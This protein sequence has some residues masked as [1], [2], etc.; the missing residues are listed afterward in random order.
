MKFFNR[1]ISWLGFNLRVLQEAQKDSV[2]LFERI[3]FLSIYS[4]NLD[5]FFR[6]RYSVYNSLKKI[7]K[8]TDGQVDMSKSEEIEHLINEQLP[9]F[10]DILRNEILPELRKQNIHLYYDET[11]SN[12]TLED[13]KSLFL[14]KILAYIQPKFLSIGESTD[15]IQNNALYLFVVLEDDDNDHSYALVNIPDQNLERF[16]TV[17]NKNGE[18][19][20][21]FLDDI[22][23]NNLDSIF[24]D[25]KVVSS[26]SIKLTRNADIDIEDEWSDLFEEQVVA[27]IKKR[28]M[29]SPARLLY[30]R[31]MPDDIKVF[32]AK[33]FDLGKRN[34]IEGGKYHNLKDL[35]SL[36]N[37]VGGVLRYKSNPPIPSKNI[38]NNTTIF[39]A[40]ASKD[41]IV[42]V[43][44]QS[45]DT[46]LRFFNE[47][48]IDPYVQELKV[49]LYRVA[50]DSLITNALISAARNGKKVTAFVELKARFDE[51]NNLAWAKQMKAAGVRII[52]SIPGMKVHAKVALVKRKNGL[53]AKYYS[54]LSTGNFNEKTARFYTDH[55]L[56][57]SNKNIT[58]EIDI[59]FAYL[60]SRR[61]PADFPF[62]AFE[63]LLV[64]GFN[65]VNKFTQL[66]EREI[67]NAKA[68]KTASIVIKVN[69]LEERDM[70]RLLYKASNSG[71][72]ISLLV[73]GICCL[74]PGVD[75]QSENITVKR[76]V[77]RYLEHSRVFIFN[78]SGDT[79]VYMG[80]ADLMNRNLHRRIE[81][82]FPLY[83]GRIKNEVLAIT[84]LHLND[85]KQATILDSEGKSHI[86]DGVDLT[87]DS[88]Q[89]IYKYIKQ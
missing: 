32:L 13:V 77:G 2:P 15:H 43:P 51:A 60:S 33:Y 36:P 71:V 47:A 79:D 27:M 8:K 3:Q 55:I 1:D 24:R 76:I 26:Y 65:L 72:K 49:T 14:N 22:V 56:F 84:N 75:G 34:I 38:N 85:S 7:A 35:S 52:Y 31:T 6:V 54:L 57:T 62:L 88:Q 67:A 29:G 4:S 68:G 25:K 64:A 21:L 70:I 10:G 74:V 61:P 45:Y 53:V 16:V 9:L 20:V 89:E 73:R 69:N 59:L 23:R 40:I 18:L 12:E 41:E 63:H 46:V 44:Y 19:D 48:A 66:V 37:P 80:S 42:H 58:R 82:V 39:D 5:E 30:E 50:S 11:I 28:E 81:V 87:V 17:P 83:D 86:V 78:N